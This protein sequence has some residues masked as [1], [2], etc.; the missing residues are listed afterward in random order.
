[1][2][3]QA[4]FRNRTALAMGAC[5]AI[6]SPLGIAIGMGITNSYDEN[7]HR[8]LIVTGIFDSASAGILLYM[9]LVDLIAVD[10]YSNRIRSSKILATQAFCALFLG[11]ACLS[12]IGVWA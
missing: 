9:A 7:S 5:F 2:D 6:T 8:A 3:I 12:V 11:A 1:M 4:G 10:F